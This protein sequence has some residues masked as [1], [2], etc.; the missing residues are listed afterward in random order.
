[1]NITMVDRVGPYR[2]GEL[3][4]TVAEIEAVLGPA[5]YKD[6]TDKAEY[7]WGFEVDG[8]YTAQ[9]CDLGLQ[10]ILRIR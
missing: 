6:D 2:T 9:R 1:M 8:V 7:S 3:E 5:N 4:A 10:G